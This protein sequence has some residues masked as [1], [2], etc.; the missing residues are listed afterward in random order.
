MNFL[1]DAPA[2]PTSPVAIRSMMVELGMEVAVES[3]SAGG[4]P[5]LLR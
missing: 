4:H 3:S 1:R 2:N 5:F